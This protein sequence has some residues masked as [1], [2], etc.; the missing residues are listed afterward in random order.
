MERWKNR[1]PYL[2][3]LLV[4]FYLLPVFIRDT[5]SAMVMMLILMP[6]I[7]FTASFIYGWRDSLDIA[8]PFL[9]A[10]FFMPSLFTS[11]YNSSA[12]VYAP[13]YGVIAG[14]GNAL[15][16]LFHRKRK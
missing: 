15:G 9:V 8:F 10:L 3:V 7:C 14:L 4:D 2:V 1:L 11:F 6:F 13:T 16:A 12:W 5:G